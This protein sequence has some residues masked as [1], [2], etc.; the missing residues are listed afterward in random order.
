MPRPALTDRPR[1]AQQRCRSVRAQRTPSAAPHSFRRRPPPR[2]R[3]EAG[4]REGTPQRLSSAAGREVAPP[5]SPP[6]RWLRREEETEEGSGREG[7]AQGRTTCRGSTYSPLLPAG[8][9][10]ALSCPALPARHH[11][12]QP[13]DGRAALRRGVAPSGLPEPLRGRS[14]RLSASPR[15]S[16][17]G[18][19]ERGLFRGAIAVGIGGAAFSW[20]A[21]DGLRAAPPSAPA[22]ARE[23]PLSAG[24]RPIFGPRCQRDADCLTAAGGLL[25]AGLPGERQDRALR[26][27]GFAMGP[28][29]RCG[30]SAAQCPAGGRL[31]LAAVALRWEMA[32]VCG[33]WV[34]S[35]RSHRAPREGC[36]LSGVWLKEGEKCAPATPARAQ[37]AGARSLNPRQARLEKGHKKRALHHLPG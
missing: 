35:V 19:W 26:C 22:P 13:A 33:T 14:E 23:R 37:R 34:V 29:Q 17:C 12:Q 24:L 1:Q 15:S 5:P 3:R 27:H 28:R 32:C 36:A 18:E 20:P 11:A 21:A 25:C 6:R 2:A 4:G 7:P 30:L 8:P 9:C 10:P 16:G 31:R